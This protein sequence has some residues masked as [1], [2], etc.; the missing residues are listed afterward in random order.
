MKYLKIETLDKGWCDRDYILLHAA[1]QVL[2]D[3][4]E[5]EKPDRIIDWGAND[6]HRNAWREMRELFRWWKRVRPERKSPL[7]D[8]RLKVP[9]M[10]FKEIPGSE[11]QELIEPDKRKYVKYYQA[12]KKHAELEQKWDEEDQRNLHRL[13]NVRQ[14][15]WT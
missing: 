4:I 8:K 15:M 11:Y 10:K 12:M 2:V 5:K 13:I 1:F 14:F 3:F 7:D 9:P 6:E